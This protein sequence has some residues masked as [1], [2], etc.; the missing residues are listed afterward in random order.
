M[1]KHC[2]AIVKD[3]LPLEEKDPWSFTLPCTINNMRFDKALADL[4]ASVSVMPYSTFP[5]LGVGKL[6]STKLI[7]E[8]ADRTVKRLKGLAENVLVGIDKF[9]FPIDFIVLDMPED[10]KTLLILRRPFLSTVYAKIDVFK[11]KIAL[12]VGNDKIV[13]KSDNPTSHMIMKVHMLGLRERMELDLEARL[14]GEALILNR[15]EDPE[16]RDFIELNNLNE[17]LELRNDQIEDLVVTDFS[18]EENIDAYWDK[19]MGDV[20]FEKPFCRSAYVEARRFDGFITVSNG[21][22][23]VTYQMARSHPMFKHLSNEQCNK[24]RPLLQVHTG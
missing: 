2:S 18:V 17:P 11:R 5:N 7:I 15:S 1:N 9:V 10:S 20:I 8:L 4:G 24:I 16:F 6:A 22:D 19:E 12:R 3:A 14:I 13:F 23:S 21:K